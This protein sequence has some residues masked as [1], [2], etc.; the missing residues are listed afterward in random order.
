MVLHQMNSKISWTT[1]RSNIFQSSPKPSPILSW[2]RRHMHIRKT[3]TSRSS[4]WHRNDRPHRAWLTIKNRRPVV[5]TNETPFRPRS[6]AFTQ[7]ACR[8]TPRAIG[9]PQRL[10]LR[11]ACL[12]FSVFFGVS[13]GSTRKDVSG[14]RIDRPRTCDSLT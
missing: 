5:R 7:P 6:G 12:T 2:G 3:R 10:D 4:I 9:F 11:I 8:R 13:H 1:S 14:R